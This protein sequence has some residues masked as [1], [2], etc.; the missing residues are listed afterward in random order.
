[1]PP[2]NT[3]EVEIAYYKANKTDFLQK[4]EGK[5]ALIKGRELLGVFDSPTSAYA[6]GLKR[7]GNVPML[8][9]HIQREEP[10][11]WIPALQLGL[12]RADLQG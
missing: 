1:M 3:L 8:I 2:Q 5:Y 4:Y 12:I 10:K 7:L 9:V 11:S 6:D